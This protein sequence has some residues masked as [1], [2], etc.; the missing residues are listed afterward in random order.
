MRLKPKDIPLL[1][2]K[3]AKEQGNRCRL[4]SV[5]LSSVVPCLDH[6]HITGKIR[7]VL[8]GNCNGI[9]GKIFNLVRRAKRETTA[10]DFINQVKNYWI[11]YTDNPRQEEHPL[12][13]TKDEKRIARN[14]KARLRRQKNKV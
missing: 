8:C 12:H 10:I 13:R 3:L 6:D 11:T 9:E 14:K 4:C 5:D 1:R 2:D 7:A